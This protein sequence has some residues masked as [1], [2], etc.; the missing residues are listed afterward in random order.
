MPYYLVHSGT[1]LYRVGVAGDSVEVSLPSG[2]TLSSA[3]PCRFAILN[4]E[5][6][7][8]N[9][10]SANFV[11]S[12]I[13]LSTRLLNIAGPG[14]SVPTLASGGS[15]VLTGEYRYRVTFAIRDSSGNVLTES[16]Y[17][18]IAG[19]ITLSANDVDLS[20][21][22]TSGTSGVNARRIYRS[23][24]GG[25]DFFLLTTIADNVTTTYTDNASDFDLAL[26]PLGHTL[27]NAPGVD[28][29]DRL[30][31]IASWKDRLWASPLDAPD[32]VHYTENRVSH[33][34]G[35]SQFITIKP[36]GADLVGVTAFAVRR[37]DLV[38]GKRRSVWIL[39]GTPPDTI[40][41]IQ[42]F[43]G[44][45]P[46]SQDATIVVQDVV[47]YLAEDGVYRI[48]GAGV[49]RIS[50]AAVHPWFTTEDF[51]NRGMFESATM[52]WNPLTNALELHLAAAGATTLNRW[53]TYDLKRQQWL[54]PHLTAAFTP[55]MSGLMEDE[56]ALLTPIMGS[57]GGHL[58]RENSSTISDD[59]SAIDFDVQTK[60]HSMQT[61]DID[62]FFGQ[63]SVISKIELAGTLTITP[64]V[65]GLN[66]SAG[67]AI[68]HTLTTG[69]ER[70]R[71]LG[72]G[73]YVKLRFQEAT[74]SQ[75]CELYGFE[76]PYHELGRR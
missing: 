56:D 13:D 4:R 8:V 72:T 3:R 12:A 71:R 65:G 48:S 75:S 51:F 39:R 7:V 21:I 30:R 20:S 53:V 64:Y 55:T 32:R 22:P 35:A 18:D 17:S 25:V 61:P 33:A 19:P 14:S 16:P 31:L 42:I 63:L 11:V 29:T 2:V 6:I 38:V 59:G 76:L 43:E 27:G 10:P 68:S 5:V 9:S 37:D 52:T 49:A 67:T 73:R 1:K 28:S 15:G 34:W 40:E 36:V 26:L 47:Y 74:D 62:K 57:S 44:P 60:F 50:E 46:L 41:A 45:G 58:Y 69:R 23:T 54:G 66:A 24:N 70:L